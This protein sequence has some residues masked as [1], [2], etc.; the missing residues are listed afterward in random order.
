MNTYIILYRREK[1]VVEK[2]NKSLYKSAIRS[3]N[4]IRA[5]LLEL[6]TEMPYEKITITDIVKKADINR[7]TFYAHFDNIS[8]VLK[9]ITAS[10]ID[11]LSQRLSVENMQEMILSPLAILQ[12][13]TDFIIKNQDI[14][15]RLLSVDKIGD[16]LEEAKLASIM[17]IMRDLEPIEDKD[18][19]RLYASLDFCIGGVL[20]MYI[21]ILLERVPVKLEESPEAISGIIQPLVDRFAAYEK[22]KKL[23]HAEV[24]GTTEVE[25][26]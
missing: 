19:A 3:R 17:R 4:I 24:A 14:Y 22:S 7:G 5:A 8:D 9:S 18:K 23:A 2:R 20:G 16:V 10:F 26:H 25:K 13:I 6:M 12:E 21:D 15:R 11:E 1:I